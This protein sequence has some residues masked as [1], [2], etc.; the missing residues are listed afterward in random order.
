MVFFA[1]ESPRFAKHFLYCVTL[2][3]RFRLDLSAPRRLFRNRN[4]AKFTAGNS[5]SV[6]GLWVQRV[7]V[8]WLTWDLTHSAAWLG[9]VG[10]A[11]FLP[12]IIVA[13]IAGVLADRFDRRRIAVTGQMLATGQAATLAAL[14]LTGHITP[15]LIFGLQLFSGFVQ[16][17]MQTARL[18][19][20]PNLL[21][22]E[23]LGSGIAITSLTFNLARIIGPALAGV[24]ITTIGVSFAFVL[25]AL[26]YVGVIA[27]LLS[28][29]L[30]PHH[31]AQRVHRSIIGGVWTE[32]SEGVRYTFSHPTLRWVM[33][34]VALS[35]TLIW[36]LSD[37]LAGIADQEFGRAAAGLAI[38]TSAQGVGAIIG[39][40]FLAQH[41]N[42][43][44]ESV[45]I[46]AMAFNGAFI[47]AFA[48]TKIFWLAVP[49]LMVSGI[50]GV[51][52]G[53]GSQTVA[54]TTA[55]DRMRGRT[56]S[57]WYAITRFGPAMG[58]L[59]LGAM[60]QA[61]GFTGPI[62]AAGFV[63]ASVALLFI[64]RRRQTVASTEGV[65]AK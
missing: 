13:P 42:K 34:M 61:L 14:A 7:A 36:P 41:G 32:M 19:L 8:G 17:L 26:T 6:V 64:M 4:F 60:S 44:I 59:G 35:S 24:L 43:N 33:P 15:L 53:V 2:M 48:I 47:A 65:N 54:Q 52:V 63:T 45:F 18:V 21:P 37:L 50:F 58:A 28:L 40:L 39:G 29:S 25:N 55:D 16:P 46:G 51:M 11:E 12:A 30:P 38:L 1:E 3:F 62:F 9:A 31:S 10:M 49:L 22:R 5:V 57:V 20:V 56:L 27:A 23:D